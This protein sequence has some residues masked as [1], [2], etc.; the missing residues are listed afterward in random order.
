MLTTLYFH[1]HASRLPLP[2]SIEL[3]GAPAD[4]DQDEESGKRGF[5]VYAEPP[6]HGRGEAREQ[7]EPADHHG[8]AGEVCQLR[9]GEGT[10][11]FGSAWVVDLRTVSLPVVK[12]LF[13]REWVCV[14]MCL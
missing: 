1:T 7:A 13:F 14:V 4:G 6:A 8:D 2:L 11:V 3:P 5:D 12:R 9:Q 10:T